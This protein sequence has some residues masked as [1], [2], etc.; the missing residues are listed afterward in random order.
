M[1]DFSSPNITNYFG[2]P[3]SPANF[4][5]PGKRPLSSMCPA[6]IVNKDGDVELVIGASGGTKITTAVALVT[7]RVSSCR[8][9]SS[10]RINKG[11]PIY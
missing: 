6:I 5:K 10:N 9:C 8:I 2:L 11:S 1:D 7:G 3:P 4:I